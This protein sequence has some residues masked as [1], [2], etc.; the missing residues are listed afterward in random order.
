V[1]QPRPPVAPPGATIITVELAIFTGGTQIRVVDTTRVTS[2]HLRMCRGVRER[3]LCCLRARSISTR[4]MCTASAIVR[5]VARA[6]S[7]A[8]ARSDNANRACGR[9]IIVFTCSDAGQK[10]YPAPLQ[11]TSSSLTAART[12]A[13]ESAQRCETAVASSVCPDTI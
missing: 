11:R 1:L 5:T 9:A 12:S 2:T 10:C 7:S 3:T 4:G 8:R 6:D 13:P